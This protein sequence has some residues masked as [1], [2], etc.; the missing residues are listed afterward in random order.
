MAS[1]SV[2]KDKTFGK[3]EQGVFILVLAGKGGEGAS[4]GIGDTHQQGGVGQQP[5]GSGKRRD[6]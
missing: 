4:S 6:G 2:P 3:A 5:R 1:P